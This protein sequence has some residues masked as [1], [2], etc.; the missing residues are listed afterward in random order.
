MKHMD[1]NGV[2]VIFDCDGVLVDTEGAA[3]RVLA[4]LLSAEGLP[5]RPS[6]L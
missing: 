2:A 3:N 1:R 4:E 5:T 6:S